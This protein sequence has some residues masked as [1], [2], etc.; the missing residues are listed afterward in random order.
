MLILRTSSISIRRKIYVAVALTLF[1]ILT[2]FL[3]YIYNSRM[4]SELKQAREKAETL[5]VQ[6]LLA[7]EWVRHQGGIYTVDSL[8]LD[9]DK[10]YWGTY[11]FLS[12]LSSFSL[13]TLQQGFRLISIRPKNEKNLPNATEF[14]VLKNFIPGSPNPESYVSLDEEGKHLYSYIKPI[15]AQKSCIHCH[16]EKG[17]IEGDVLGALSLSL[18]FDEAMLELHNVKVMFILLGIMII[19][20]TTLV[21][22]LVLG[23]LFLS[24]FHTFLQTIKEA[25]NGNWNHRTEMKTGDEWEEFSDTYNL[26]ATTIEQVLQDNE[27]FYLQTILSISSAL[28]ARDPYT[29]GHST[30]VAVIARAIATQMGLSEHEQT[31]IEISAILH[32]IGKIGIPDEVLK[33]EDHLTD[34]EW[35]II[36]KH[37][38]LGV[39]ILEPIDSLKNNPGVLYHHER[40]DGN[41]YPSGLKGYAIPLAAR[42]I[43]VADAYDAMTSNRV[44]RASCSHQQ[45]LSVIVENAGSQFCPQVVAA[46]VSCQYRQ[47]PN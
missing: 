36:K 32:D 17:F 3:I 2:P 26:M 18:P 13:S 28:D 5:S 21:L 19:G 16:E 6:I 40:F 10:Q 46:F 20:G 37:P 12:S 8:S 11:K 35:K 30:N 9:A 7:G 15:I 34:E 14:E 1:L 23:K 22:Y 41:G 39:K 42:I 44:Y 27:K 25:M 24:P 38:I 43:S 31:Q 29:K 47:T 33:K 45:A 4:Q